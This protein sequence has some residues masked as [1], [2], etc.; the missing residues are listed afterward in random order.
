MRRCETGVY[1]ALRR[2][3]LSE[4]KK[5]VT[6]IWSSSYGSSHLTSLLQS[7]HTIVWVIRHV[8]EFKSRCA[9]CLCA[10]CGSNFL[11]KQSLSHGTM[12]R[13]HPCDWEPQTHR[14]A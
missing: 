4:M 3:E 7:L 8:V 14:S 12:N 2:L 11:T 10:I 13:G 9:T 5:S 1:A 6:T